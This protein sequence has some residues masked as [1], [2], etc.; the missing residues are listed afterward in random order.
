MLLE[1]M[2]PVSKPGMVSYSSSASALCP[3]LVPFVRFGSASAILCLRT[4]D[5]W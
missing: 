5:E 4:L 1:L 2:H 3:V